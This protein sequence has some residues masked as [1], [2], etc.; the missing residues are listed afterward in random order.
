MNKAQ[1]KFYDIGYKKGVE[2]TLKALKLL[3]NIKP[4][5]ELVALVGKQYTDAQQTTVSDGNK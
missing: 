1:K 3:Y 2:E 4:K 5:K